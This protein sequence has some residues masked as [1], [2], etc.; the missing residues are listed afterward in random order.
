[1]LYLNAKLKTIYKIL[2]DNLTLTSVVFECL[3]RKLFLDYKK[4]NFN[5]CCIW[6]KYSFLLFVLRKWFNFNKCCI[7]IV[8]VFDWL[9]SEYNLTLTSVVFEYLQWGYYGDSSNN[10]TLTSVVFEFIKTNSFIYPYT[11][12]NF[13]KCCIWIRISSGFVCPNNGI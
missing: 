7:W 12:F 2:K 11:K 3:M 9:L 13:N 1:M 5:K 10:L 6:I 8:L 4:F